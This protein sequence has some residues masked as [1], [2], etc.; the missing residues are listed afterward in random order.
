MSSIGTAAG[1]VSSIG[2]AAGVL[3]SCYIAVV[4]GVCGGGED[5]HIGAGGI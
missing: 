4:C 1:A 2:T 5:V 3:T